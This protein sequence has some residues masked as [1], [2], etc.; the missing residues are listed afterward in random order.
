MSKHFI[1]AAFCSALSLIGTGGLALAETIGG[2]E[3]ST[4]GTT[5]R[6]TIGESEAPDW[7]WLG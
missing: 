5:S 1:A 2:Y 3:C 4:I 6:E 7:V